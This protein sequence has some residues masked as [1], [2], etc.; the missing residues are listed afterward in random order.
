MSSLLD[1][2][3][4]RSGNLSLDWYLAALQQGANMQLPSWTTTM[5]GSPAIAIDA[6]FLG[7]VA[8]IGR[9]HGVVAAAVAARG[10]LV[11]QVRPQ[12]RDKRDGAEGSLFGSAELAVI[13]QPAARITRQRLLWTAETHVSYAGAAYF[14]ATP[15]EGLRLLRPDLVDVLIASNADAND[16]AGP[17]A[18]D[19][20]VIGW[21]YYPDGR[22]KGHGRK[23]V[24]APDE[25][26]QWAPE[27]DPVCWWRGES[28]VTSIV[29]EVSTDMQ[30]SDHL[31]RFYKNAATPQL[32]FSLKEAKTAAQVQDFADV[33]NGGH[34]GVENAYK[35]LFLGGGA[36][37]TVVGADLS[38][39]QYQ[40][41]QGGHESRIA[42]RSR[43][44]AIVLGIREGMAGSALNAG[45]YTST[46]RMWSDGWVTPTADG[47]CA[48]LQQIIPAPNVMAE[49]TYD[50]T[51][52][53]FLQEDRKDEAE[54]L[55]QRAV[56]LRNL[57]DAG[58]TPDTAVTA[59][60]TGDYRR[61]KH[62][63]LF[64]VQLQP[65]N[66]GE[67][68]TEPNDPADTPTPPGA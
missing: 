32:V 50:P 64:S 67:A 56:T 53:A 8:N 4:G 33:V 11:S 31:S 57:L 40:D 27:P 49:L 3:L 41:I 63:G 16:P 24:L 46:R 65:P 61:L 22:N 48:T 43:V 42:A 62:S 28:W 35:N 55:A 14:K 37:V 1:R 18:E 66:T 36:D 12:W 26:A 21:V 52:I 47:L 15:G 38:K 19:S 6:N 20:E 29:E 9:A 5:P 23:I 60:A 10:G 7:Y 13:E 58:F 39:M 45:N 25:V 59:V 51:R 34:A 68:A 54:I 17:Q 44:P 30:A 2:I